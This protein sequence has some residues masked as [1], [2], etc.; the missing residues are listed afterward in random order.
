MKKRIV[1]L[2]LLFIFGRAFSGIE[3]QYVGFET[4]NIGLYYSI[5]ADS[6]KMKLT[7]RSSNNSAEGLTL[8]YEDGKLYLVNDAEKS[9]MDFGAMPR[10]EDEEAAGL[11]DVDWSRLKKTGKKLKIASYKCKEYKYTDDEGDYCLY[12]TKDKKLLGSLATVAKG[13]FKGPMAS[14]LFNMGKNGGVVFG[15]KENGRFIFKATKV[16]IRHIPS[17]TFS[18]KS[19]KKFDLNS[20]MQQMKQQMKG[21][22]EE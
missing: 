9:Y 3:L 17:E 13:L 16:K 19:Y 1:I 11:S 20:L 7:F 10:Q 15:I 5:L 21:I 14:T 18:L 22:G 4:N 2:C 12:I 6:G 8:M